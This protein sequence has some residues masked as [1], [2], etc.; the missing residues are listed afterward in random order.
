MVINLITSPSGGGA[1]VLVRELGKRLD[2]YEITNEVY[3]FN[4][5]NS[6]I[7][8]N[9]NET[10]LNVSTRNPLIVLKLRQLFRQKLQEHGNL[11]I[12]AH[13][14]WPFFFTVLASFG[15]NIRL[16]YTEHN[17][18]NK[19]RKIPFLKYIERLF[20]GRY[21]TI[22]CISNGVY[23]SLSKWV[24]KTLTHRLV[25]INNGARIYGF[26][27]R[28]HSLDQLKFV[29][30]GSLTDKKNLCTAI[31][32]LARMNTIGWQY[33]IIGEGPERS[34]LENLIVELGVQKRVNLVGWSDQIEKHLHNADVQLIPS[35]WEGFGLVAVEG[36]STGLPVVASNVAGLR[37]VLDLENPAVFLV[38]EIMAEQAW[39]NNI[40]DCIFALS[41]NRQH[42]AEASR[43]Q[44]EKFGLDEMIKAYCEEYQKFIFENHS[45]D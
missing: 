29:S 23:E 8:L 39:L 7:A 4:N 33:D 40:H 45:K 11:V 30:V 12:H 42:I 15:L 22:I 19:R 20:Y 24:G 34:D 5:S 21:S 18:F 28:D 16:I 6:S 36:M 27:Y 43:K 31:K 9:D 1:E 32:A 14:T 10:V 13:L 38:D 3:Y 2:A 41:T 37:D 25:V 35:L 26:K 44:A 17:T